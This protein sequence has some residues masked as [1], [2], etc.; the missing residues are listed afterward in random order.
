MYALVSDFDG[1]IT[2][3][4][5]FNYLSEH[6]FNDE[7]LAPWREYLAGKK[8]HFNALNEMFS[9]LRES[10]ADFKK[11]IKTINFDKV[12]FKVAELCGKKDIPV[13]ICSAGCDY[14]IN[15]LIGNEIKKY[16]INLVTNFGYY[17]PKTG[18]KMTAPDENSP[19]F[20][21]KIGISKQ[22]IVKKLQNDGYMCIYAG[23]GPPDFEAAQIADVVFAKKIML[24]KCQTAGIKTE[25]FDS[26]ENV[27]QFI[28]DL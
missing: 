23:D 21:E 1:T 20:D 8:T 5:F 22:N 28:K 18:L 16:N 17:S 25:K 2:D 9:Q 13:Y 15:E 14:Y 19:Y 4:D 6:Y 10:E 24:Q 7:M 12:F 26:F 27:Y 11:F 3:D